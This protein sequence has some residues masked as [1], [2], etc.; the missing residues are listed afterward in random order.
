MKP[1]V[2]V[3]D[4]H[5]HFWDLEANYLPWLRDEPQIPFGGVGASG[6][7]RTLPRSAPIA[8]RNRPASSRSS[9]SGGGLRITEA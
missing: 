3:I 7:T 1:P 5:Q 2:P 6:R 4:A 8:A 9:G